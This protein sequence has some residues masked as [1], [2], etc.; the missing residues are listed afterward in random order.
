MTARAAA[1]ANSW[2]GH[3]SCRVWMDQTLVHLLD[4]LLRESYRTRLQ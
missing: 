3:Q 4:E 2:D 1:L